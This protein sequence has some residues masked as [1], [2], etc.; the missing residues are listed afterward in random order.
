MKTLIGMFTL[1]LALLAL[2][3]FASAQGVSDMLC[4]SVSDAEK[5][6]FR[7]RVLKDQAET[8]LR[9]IEVK[10]D[11]VVA[12]LDE[13]AQAL[14]TQLGRKYWDLLLERET[15]R[16]LLRGSEMR[17]ANAEAYLEGSKLRCEE[18]KKD[19]GIVK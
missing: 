5:D 15:A 16:S 2:A 6:V 10:I 13:R 18:A 3:G 11:K 14:S 7:K 1:V 9:E 17:H 19:L 12:E 4:R 8:T